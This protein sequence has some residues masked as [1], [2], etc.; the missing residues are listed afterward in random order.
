[1]LA[2]SKT[3]MKGTRKVPSAILT[4]ILT[5]L[6]GLGGIAVLVLSAQ[7]FDFNATPYFVVALLIGGGLYL[8]SFQI[9]YYEMARHIC[10]KPMNQGQQVITLDQAGVT[11]EGTSTHWVTPWAMI[12]DVVKTRNTVA[13]VAGG[14][15][16][17]I[18]R[19]AIGDKAAVDQLIADI[20]EQITHA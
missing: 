2:A 11:Y 8:L 18:P 3:L 4:N 1:M 9:L 20:N 15:G 13:L 7:Y 14:I 10:D 19:D 16:F 5:L 17:A 6:C 12:D